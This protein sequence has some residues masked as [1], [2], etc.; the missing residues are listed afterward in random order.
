MLD[1]CRL[2]A[3]V[4]RSDVLDP[5]NGIT[6]GKC[7]GVCASGRLRDPLLDGR[8]TIDDDNDGDNVDIEP[9]MVGPENVLINV[10]GRPLPDVDVALRAP[11]L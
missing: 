6:D 4:G 5:E 11:G 3:V 2:S 10:P 8:N 9:G 7:S 1:D